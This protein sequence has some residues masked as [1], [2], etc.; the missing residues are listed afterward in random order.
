VNHSAR[1]ASGTWSRFPLRG[2]HSI[3]HRLETSF[4]GSKS[5]AQAQAA[6]ALP[7]YW[8]ISPKA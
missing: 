4:A 6:T 1:S 3:S 5:P 2:G 7:L 8:T